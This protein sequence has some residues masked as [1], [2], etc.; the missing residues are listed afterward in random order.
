MMWDQTK[1]QHM[2]MAK[3]RMSRRRMRMSRKRLACSFVA[4]DVLMMMMAMMRYDDS[5]DSRKMQ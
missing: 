4:D 5:I 3:E 2:M 1:R